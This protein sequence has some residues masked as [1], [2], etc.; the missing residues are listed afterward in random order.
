MVVEGIYGGNVRTYCN[1]ST[2]GF[3]RN[4]RKAHTFSAKHHLKQNSLTMKALLPHVKVSQTEFIK[5]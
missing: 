2:D 5:Y 3:N 4:I 1:Y